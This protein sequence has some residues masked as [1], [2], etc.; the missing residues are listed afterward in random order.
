VSTF[1]VRSTHDDEVLPVERPPSCLQPSPP[2]L[3]GSLHRFQSAGMRQILAI[4]KERA[5][6]VKPALCCPSRL[7]YERD[8]SRESGVLEEDGC[9]RFAR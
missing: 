4:A 1:V 9:G 2:H 3:H 6:H 8:G 5:E 7:A